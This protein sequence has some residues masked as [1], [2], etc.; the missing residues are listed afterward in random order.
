MITLGSLTFGSEANS[1][2]QVNNTNSVEHDY[3]GNAHVLSKTGK[4]EIITLN[5][6][7]ALC[8]QDFDTISEYI[9]GNIGEV[10]LYEDY[11]GNG[12]TVKIMNESLEY[13]LI[14]G[15]VEFNIQ[16]LVM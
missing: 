10:V 6:Q 5:P 16:L 14:Q 15:W 2:L 3:N 7:C 8:S 11:S 4:N 1:S 13:S 9:K 12:Y